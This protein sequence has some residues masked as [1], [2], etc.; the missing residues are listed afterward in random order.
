MNWTQLFI[1]H[2]DF[3]VDEG[4]DIGLTARFNTFRYN[5]DG[6]FRF[7][8]GLTGG[9]FT[10]SPNTGLIPK[11]SCWPTNLGK[12]KRGYSPAATHHVQANGSDTVRSWDFGPQKD[13]SA[14]Q[15]KIV[16]LDGVFDNNQFAQLT[17]FT[18]P[19][20]LTAQYEAERHHLHISHLV[21]NL[22][23]VVTP[24]PEKKRLVLTALLRDTI[25]KQLGKQV[26][27]VIWP[28]ITTTPRPLHPRADDLE[29]KIQ[30]LLTLEDD[31]LRQLLKSAGLDEAALSGACCQFIDMQKENLNGL[32]LNACNFYHAYLKNTTFDKAILDHANLCSADIP[33]S[34][35]Q[36]TS[37]KHTNFRH[38]RLRKAKFNGTKIFDTTNFQNADL[39]KA[40]FINAQLNASQFDQAH[41]QKANFNGANLSFINFRGANLSHA[42]LRN[43]NLTG[44]DFTDANLTK[45]KLNHANLQGTVFNWARI[46]GADFKNAINADFENLRQVSGGLPIKTGQTIQVDSELDYFEIKSKQID[47]AISQIEQRLESFEERLEELQQRIDDS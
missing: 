17:G 34:S 1:M 4:S 43:A 23:T 38:A 39:S 36:G 9:K 28:P 44:A 18:K 8:I 42:D 29:A 41:L 46:S 2:I 15:H 19:T 11:D 20:T 32:H 37:L 13:W 47:V 40:E 16:C 35:W 21:I 14:R 27:R 6:L 24:V 7:D 25:H 33:K 10:I 45:A 5:L 30:Q 31:K 12:P 26:D 3:D 22:P